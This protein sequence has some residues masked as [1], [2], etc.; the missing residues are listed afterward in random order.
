M[1][2][3]INN[4]FEISSAKLFCI[5]IHEIMHKKRLIFKTGFKYLVRT[6]ES[7]EK[8]AVYFFESNVF[9]NYLQDKIKDID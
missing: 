7:Q 4:Q 6:P 1:E 2:D 3:K 8:E 9:G 5:L